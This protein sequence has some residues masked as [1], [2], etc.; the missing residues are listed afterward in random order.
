MSIVGRMRGTIGIA[1]DAEGIGAFTPRRPPKGAGNDNDAD[2][3][4]G[5]TN[6]DTP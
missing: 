6:K 1:A 4:R 2:A 5:R 3:G